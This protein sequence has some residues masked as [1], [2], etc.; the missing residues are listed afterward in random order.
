MVVRMFIVLETST[1]NKS[2]VREIVY[3]IIRALD[4]FFLLVLTSSFHIFFFIES[5][6]R[7]H[8]GINITPRLQDCSFFSGI[9]ILGFRKM[10]LLNLNNLIYDCRL[11]IRNKKGLHHI[12]V[13]N[14]CKIQEN[15]Q[16][17]VLLVD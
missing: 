2:T 10:L 7:I 16:Y 5:K 14:I 11:Q 15:F 4:S 8:G 6:N 13:L 17:C 9:F 12:D 3:Q 1:G